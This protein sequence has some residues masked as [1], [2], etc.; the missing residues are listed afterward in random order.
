MIVTGVFEDGSEYQ[1]TD[2]TIENGNNLKKDQTYITIKYE[3]KTINQT[4][5]VE[6]KTITEIEINK[7]PLKL[8]YIQNKEEL[9]LTGGVLK[10]KYNDGTSETVLMTSQEVT[11]SGFKN[12]NPGK[13]TISII[14][15]TKTANLEVEIIEEAKPENSNFANIKANLIRLKAYYY[16]NNPQN[17][18][19][20][21]DIELEGIQK[22]TENDNLEYYYYLSTNQNEQNITDWIKITDNQTESN[23]LQLEIDTRKIS[24]LDDLSSEDTLYLYIKEV[25]IK[26]GN[27]SIAITK[28]INVEVN[29][30]TQISLN[31]TIQ[32][33]KEEEKPNVPENN[34][35]KDDTVIPGILPQ[36]GIKITLITL[37]IITVVA[38]VIIYTKYK[39]YKEYR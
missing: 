8:Q 1:I 5:T 16:E 24:N 11:T 30:N 10:I 9:D 33:N 14:Y 17:G 23:K 27:Q 15:Q 38:S 22:S 26:G 12:E 20:I 29:E 7:K 37:T 21:F 35:P 3:T 19:S 4:I 6:D 31:G 25:A 36:T 28:A 2:Y 18:Y 13:I 34:T 39:K 32:D